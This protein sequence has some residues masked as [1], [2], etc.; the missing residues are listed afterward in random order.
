MHSICLNISIWLIRIGGYPVWLQQ[1]F[2]SIL[3]A[4]LTFGYAAML[5]VLRL[6]VC[7]TSFVR[8][9][10]RSSLRLFD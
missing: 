3:L 6:A 7:E 5:A 2:A 9:L 4:V 1:G 10:F 8:V